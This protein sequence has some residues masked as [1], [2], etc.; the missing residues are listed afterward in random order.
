MSYYAESLEL[1]FDLP[2]STVTRAQGG[3]TATDE[4]VIG[5]WVER[6]TDN[7]VL[8]LGADGRP[9]GVI[10]RMSSGKVAVAVGTVVRGKRG[11]DAVIPVGSR[12]TGTTRKESAAGA[13]ERGFVGPGKTSAVVDISNSD[14][15]V[16]SQDAASTAN[17]PAGYVDV[18]MR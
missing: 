8:L 15:Y 12:V 1:S 18:V 13:A 11:T 3:F 6:S 7:T 17:T 2:A 14:G 9:L 5:R 10:T 16:I 4:D